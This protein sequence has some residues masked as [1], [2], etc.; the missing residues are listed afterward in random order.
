MSKNGV[1]VVSGGVQYFV[2]HAA[3]LP[4]AITI[5]RR[6]ECPEGD[7]RVRTPVVTPSSAQN[8]DCCYWL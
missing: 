5:V 2:K 1:C 8:R 4:A 7:L 6:V 3:L